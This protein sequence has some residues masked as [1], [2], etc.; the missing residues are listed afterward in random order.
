MAKVWA[1]VS[2]LSTW[3]DLKWFGRH[4]CGCVCEGVFFHW[5]LTSEGRPCL[6]VGQILKTQ[7]KGCESSNMAHYI[8]GSAPSLNSIPRTY[9][10]Q[11]Q[12]WLLQVSSEHTHTHTHTHTYI[13]RTHAH[14]CAHTPG[15]MRAHSKWSNV[16]INRK[17]WERNRIPAEQ[18]HS[19]LSTSWVW[20][21]CDQLPHAPVAICH[22]ERG[23]LY[24][25]T[26]SNPSQTLL[27]HV[28]KS[29]I[30]LQW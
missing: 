24:L 29:N 3:L 28:V 12:N 15:H 30:L 1:C 17:R 11:R 6:N 5:D 22:T 20:V 8:K 18:Q 21:P 14:T 19:S 16:N 27:P 7:L 2:S 10:V 13:T 25:Q 4:T 23:G 9:F 26:E